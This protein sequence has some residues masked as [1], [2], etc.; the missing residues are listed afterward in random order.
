MRI[1]IVGAGALGGYFGANLH[2]AGAD[3]CFYARDPVKVE[4]IAKQG[5]T[6]GEADGTSRTVFPP[7]Y[8]KIEDTG[9]VDLILLLVKSYHTPGAAKDI[10]RLSSSKPDILSLQ[11]GMGNLEELAALFPRRRLFG[12]V[13]YQA[14][15]EEK[16]GSVQHTGSGKTLIAPVYPP[17]LSAAREYAEYLTRNGL[18]SEALPPTE[19]ELLRWYKLLINC[20]INPLS[21]LYRLK[22]G[23]LIEDGTIRAEMAALAQ[24]GVAVAESQGIKLDFTSVWQSILETCR[25][26]AAN[27]SSML[28]DVERGRET[29]IDAINGSIAALGA[30]Q[31]IATPFQDSVIRRL[32]AQ[33]Y[34]QI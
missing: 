2:H 6:V 25:K 34:D 20:A 18:A 3:I 15:Y 7:I 29:E 11:N 9:A 1:L 19:L 5:L 24:E 21:A 8:G 13:T 4:M 28:S 14:A 12:G 31:G 30:K 23:A 26:T 16:T 17:R 33:Y 22:N 32:K 10:A 27:R